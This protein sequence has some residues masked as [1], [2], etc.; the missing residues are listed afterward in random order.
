MN[1]I[2]HICR[3][4]SKVSSDPLQPSHT[5]AVRYIIMNQLVRYSWSN[6]Q[7]AVTGHQDCRLGSGRAQTLRCVQTCWP[8]TVANKRLSTKCKVMFSMWFKYL[9]YSMTWKSLY[10]FHVMCF[11]D[12]QFASSPHQNETST[13]IRFYALCWFYLEVSKRTQAAALG[14]SLSHWWKR[15]AHYSGQEACK[16]NAPGLRHQQ[17]GCEYSVPLCTSWL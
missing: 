2:I 9:F 10:N 6:N 14:T 5:K 1:W 17:Q 3:S 11:Y 4:L 12:F 7:R 16:L 8:S 15:A 13:I